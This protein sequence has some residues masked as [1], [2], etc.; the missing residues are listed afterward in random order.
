MADLI[1]SRDPQRRSTAMS[2][3]GIGIVAFAYMTLTRPWY[4]MLI[5]AP[6]ITVPGTFESTGAVRASAFMNAYSLTQ[7]GTA[8]S[9]TGPVAALGSIAGMPT[10]VVLLAITAIGIIAAAVLRNALFALLAF[11]F[12]YF[13]RMSVLN[14]RALVE[15][16]TYG[17]EFM[18]PQQGLAMFSFAIILLTALSA[19]VGIQ[20][21]IANRAARQARRA[22]G[23][24]IP[25]VFDLLYSVHQGALTR[26]AQRFE[27]QQNRQSG[28]TQ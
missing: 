24:N 8:M 16:P 18:A 19:L 12:A 17:G 22:S 21:A 23:E 10:P 7:P 20:V 13:A 4:A 2:M 25:G 3:L 15:N 11:G 5:E 9:H 26:A 1:V 28:T 14:A 27:S 6:S